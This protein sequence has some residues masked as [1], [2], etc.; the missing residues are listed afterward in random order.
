[1][2]KIKDFFKK[3]W[4]IIVGIV[5]LFF[6]AVFQRSKRLDAEANNNVIAADVKDQDLERR[7][8]ENNKQM[9]QLDT[10][11]DKINKQEQANKNDN[12]G[13]SDEEKIDF[14]KRRL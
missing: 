3:Y 2:Q 10:E 12:E 14:W 13:M 7:L 1:M 5:G 4:A 11:L 8:D 9:S 6:Y